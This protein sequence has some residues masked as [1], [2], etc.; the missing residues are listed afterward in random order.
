MNGK[1][2]NR[3]TGP[4]QSDCSE[5]WFHAKI[6]RSDGQEIARGVIQLATPSARG[7]FLP[8]DVTAALQTL[9]T[10]AS[11]ELLAEIG[12]RRVA[13]PGFQLCSG[14]RTPS[15]KPHYHFRDS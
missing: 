8:E 2:V 5:L 7:V 15:A 10:Q 13:L 14:F 6:L 4:S 1:N 3:E 12:P 11:S 9:G